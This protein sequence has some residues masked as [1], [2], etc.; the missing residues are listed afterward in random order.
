MGVATS[1]SWKPGTK[2]EGSGRP[3][4]AR[5]NRTAD[6]VRRLIALGHKDPLETLSEL[7]HE[8][9]DEAIRATAANMLAPYLHGKLVPRPIPVF[10]EQNLSI[11]RPT[12][13]DEAINNIAMISDM[14]SSGQI[15]RDWGDN[16]ITDQRVILNG[17]VDEAKILAGQA[18]NADHVIRIEGGLPSLPGTEII[19]PPI[20]G[21]APLDSTDV[22]PGPLS[23]PTPV[24]PDTTLQRIESALLAWSESGRKGNVEID[25]KTWD[26][27]PTV[28]RDALRDLF[29]KY[30]VA[31][32]ISDAPEAEA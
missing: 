12:T 16:L 3:A 31:C 17:L 6:I 1:G 13:I 11:P 15:D 26:Q 14:K 7:Q 24:V 19:M 8:S 9:K 25:E 32:P 2:V 5:N 4:G 23:A 18:A 28:S 27:M 29:D 10:L 20:G 22:S 30:G 21:S